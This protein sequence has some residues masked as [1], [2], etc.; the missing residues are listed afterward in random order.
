MKW[1]EPRDKV[2]PAF[3]AAHKAVGRVVVMDSQNPH[4]KSKYAS[5]SA[6][7]A[8][9]TPALEANELTLI[10]EIAPRCK[11]EAIDNETTELNVT[12]EDGL[13]CATTILHSSGESVRFNPYFVPVDKRTAHG[14]GSAATYVRRF[15]LVSLFALTPK[16][17]DGN[18]ASGVS[19][20]DDKAAEKK[21]IALAKFKQDQAAQL[22]TGG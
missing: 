16:D 5:L 20:K 7:M 12:V 17:D 11:A 14:H 6:V 15:S 22:N 9:I 8:V 10:Q 4:F 3:L 18:V 13:F 2:Y 19:A 21:K 1:S